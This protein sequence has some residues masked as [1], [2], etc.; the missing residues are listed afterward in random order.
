MKSCFVIMPFSTTVFDKDGHVIEISKK[1]WTWI[2]ENWI[3]KSIASYPSE[4][5][6]CIRSELKPG[7]FV[8]GIV[9]NII[10]ADI[11]IADLTGNKPNVYY[12]LGIRHGLKNGNIIISQDKDTMP[13]DLSNYF[14]FYYK[15]SSKSFENESH[16]QEF[17]QNMHK[18]LDS[19]LNETIAPDNPVADFKKNSVGAKKYLSV[20]DFKKLIKIS[21][22]DHQGL[23]YAMS[24]YEDGFSWIYQLGQKLISELNSNMSVNSKADKIDSFLDVLDKTFTDREQIKHYSSDPQYQKNF[25]LNY[26]ILNV[27][28]INIK[29]KL[30]E[31]M[32][33]EN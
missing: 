24:I 13:S 26:R 5:I 30:L 8:K 25:S 10:S 16:Y 11:V 2:Y 33:P 9:E 22:Q 21:P 12:E 14:C 23:D 15:Y 28:L 27:H 1:E 6:N 7:N 32:T 17:E 20:C 3:K 18:L 29:H 19:I 31:N 4:S